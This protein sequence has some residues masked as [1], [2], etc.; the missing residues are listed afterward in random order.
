MIPYVLYCPHVL[1]LFPC[2][3]YQ[4][5]ISIKYLT[6]YVVFPAPFRRYMAEIFM[7]IRRKT[8][9][10]LQNSKR[11]K[12]FIIALSYLCT[13]M[14][15]IKLRGTKSNIMC[16]LHRNFCLFAWF[17]YFHTRRFYSYV[18]VTIAGEGL[19]NDQF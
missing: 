18:D 19:P 16:T 10:N 9:S 13:C 15:S 2:V 11:N 5:I 3:F 1:V 14:F 8:L 12:T 4:L 17:S 7:S 6:R